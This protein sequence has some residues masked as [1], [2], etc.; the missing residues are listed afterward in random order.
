MKP[1]AEAVMVADPNSRPLTCG[2]VAGQVA[3]AGMKTLEG[4]VAIDVLL[5]VSDTVTPPAGAAVGNAIW[6]AADRSSPTVRVVGD[7][8]P[9]VVVCTTVTLAVAPPTLS[10]LAKIVTDPAAMLVTGTDVLL[11]PAA[12][13]TVAGTVATV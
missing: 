5:L 11:E 3:L 12:K 10:A 7:W 9:P 2:A 6:S 13:L 8:I 1:G 4:A